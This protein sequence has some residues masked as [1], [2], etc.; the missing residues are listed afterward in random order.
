MSDEAS[1]HDDDPLRGDDPVH[2]DPLNGDGPVMRGRAR[3]RA[4][5]AALLAKALVAVLVLSF[6]SAIVGWA[7]QGFG[8]AYI[9]TEALVA[10]LLQLPLTL[11]MVAA[12]LA[13]SLGSLCFGLFL[14]VRPSSRPSWG[15]TIFCLVE[16]ASLTFVAVQFVL[17]LSVLA[18]VRDIPY[19]ASPMS[20]TVRVAGVGEEISYDSEGSDSS[21]YYV[22]LVPDD[23]P[24][25]EPNEVLR[26]EIGPSNYYRWQDT[27]GEVEGSDKYLVYE[28]DRER[29]WQMPLW[30]ASFLPSTRTLLE[31]EPMG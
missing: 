13:L 20:G 23:L 31:F 29:I 18:P 17:P 21:T 30:R 26:F 2:D 8:G 10:K 16:G 27:F 11:V 4:S 25:V 7:M 15:L 28:S 5:K 3:R 12:L 14:L 9:G 1:V 24:G 22:Y 6:V 19:L